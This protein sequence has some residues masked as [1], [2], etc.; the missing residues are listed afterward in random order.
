MAIS[1]IKEN[2]K[3][4]T[5]Q[6][7]DVKARERETSPWLDQ[8]REARKLDD[9]WMSYMSQ[10]ESGKVFDTLSLEDGLVLY[11]KR[12]YIPKSNELELMVTRRCHDAKVAGHFGRDKAM[13]RMTRT[14]YSPDMDQWVRN[15][16]RTY[17]ACP[18][19]K[20]GRHK[21][22]GPI[23]PLVIPYRP[24]EHISMDFIM[25]LPSVSGYDQ[26]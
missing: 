15:Y 3:I 5:R 7:M 9:Q 13:E 2:H 17:D 25:E 8:I 1:T 11:K 18:R 6:I 16:V 23:K 21:E 22:Y 24:W 12:Y 26:I 14:Y 19:N 10:L 4:L 20:T